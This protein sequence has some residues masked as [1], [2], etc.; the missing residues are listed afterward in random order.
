M[1]LIRPG[2]AGDRVY[3]R[4]PQIGPRL[5][6]A[7]RVLEDAE[8]PRLI[9]AHFAT[10]GYLVGSVTRSPLVVSAYG[11]DVSVLARQ[12]LWRRAYR[13]LAARAAFLLVEGPYMRDRVIALGFSAD[14][15]RI[16]RIAA[17]LQ[18]VAFREPPSIADRPLKLLA[19]GRFVEKKGHALAISS[20]AAIRHVLPPG[21]TL[22][23]VGDGPLASS[24]HALAESLAVTDGV[25]FVGSLSRT[26]FHERLRGADL[27]LAPSVTASNGD[28][29]GGAPTTILD[30]QA[31][32]TIVVAST[33]ADIPF[34]VE[35]GRTGY[36]AAEGDADVFAQAIVRAIDDC[37]RWP[38]LALVAR[39][40]AIERH[41]DDAVAGALRVVY[42][43]VVP[44]AIPL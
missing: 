36:L 9:H 40:G 27:F 8:H 5:A 1:P 15:V 37:G 6:G 4:L 18:D 17:D 3:H 16:V 28:F 43:E 29:E 38:Q 22:E 42:G 44:E 30:A 20:F 41:S 32:G 23:I 14:R 7:Y 13:R 26:V 21:S 10:T 12:R 34:L 24:L 25:L 11:F 35:D 2:S 31:T 19:C 39:G 33:H